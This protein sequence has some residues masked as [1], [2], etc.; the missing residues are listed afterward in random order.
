MAK[1]QIN[2]NKKTIVVSEGANVMN[3]NTAVKRIAEDEYS[4]F[5][6]ESK[7]EDGGI[8]VDYYD[9]HWDR[10]IGNNKIINVKI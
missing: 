4:E 8:N 7:F 9:L 2:L 6:I 5:K 1:L 3:A 10:K